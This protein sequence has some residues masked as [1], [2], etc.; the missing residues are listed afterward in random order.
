MVASE[1]LQ[2]LRRPGFGRYFA[3]VAA[4]RATGT[5]F[6]VAG[7]LL[8][9]ER[10][11]DL[12]LA[13]LVVAA[14]MLPGALAGPFL[15][16]WL[17]V[18][19]SRRRLLVLDR[20]VTAGAL[21]ALL[22]L[23]GHG[24]NWLLP[25]LGAVYGI[26]APLSS[27]AFSSVLPEVAGEQLLG[28]ANTF[29]ATS[30]NT[31]F[32]VGPAVAGLIAGTAG[33]AMAVEVQIAAGLAL[34]VL[35]ATDA[36]FELRPEQARPGRV[37]HAVRH[38]FASI[39]RIPPLRWNT[40]VSVIYVAA[41]GMLNV[42]F[43]TY[44]VSVGAGASASGYMWAAVS[45]GSMVSAFA[46]RRLVAGLGLRLLMGVSFLAMAASV[47]LWPLAGGLAAALALIFLTGA[48]EGP[49]LVALITVR[50]RFAPAHLRGQIFSTV[51]SL[52]VAAVAVGA[53]IAGPFHAAFGTA[54]TLLAS[55]GLLGLAG[56]VSLGTESDGART[57][58]AVAAGE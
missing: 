21:G 26:T 51:G 48:V 25:V 16:G 7:V 2:L 4:A 45:V 54:A 41:W 18:S 44:A 6:N 5:M 14:A 53:A 37:L 9:L 55:G 27:G 22:L 36:T 56:L 8:V 23:A 1:T 57:A 10:T 35:I 32:I 15:G 49:S 12:T 19:V 28:I 11:G 13:G 43:P 40:V 3:V 50:Q 34:A 39:W 38:G 29:E 24:P 33:A 31:A 20:I 52:D 46:L 30:I 42:G 47:A 17:D 58:V